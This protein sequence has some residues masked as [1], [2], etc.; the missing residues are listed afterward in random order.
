MQPGEIADWT[1]K[2]RAAGATSL[3][4]NTWTP[5]PAPERSA[6]IEGEMRNFLAQW[7]P[8]VAP[9]AGDQ[10]PPDFSAQCEAMLSARPTCVSSIMGL[11]PA[12]YVARLNEAGVKWFATATT[13]AEARAAA[14]AGADA[15]IAQGAEA[16]GH[17]GAFDAD[18]AERSMA[19]LF[20]LLPAIVDAVDVPVIAAGGIGDARGFAGALALGAH[21]VMIGTA[22][23]RCPE[24][25][26]PA[27]YS[28]ALARAQPE[29]TLV[30]RA[31]SGRPGRSLATGFALAAQS[32]GAPRA[33]PYP[34]QRGLTAQMRSKA[35]K[36]NDVER[37]Q[38]WAGQSAR[39]AQ[40]R[41]AG[42][43]VQSLW[44][45]ARRKFSP[46][47]GPE[48]QFPV[49]RRQSRWRMATDSAKPPGRWRKNDLPRNLCKIAER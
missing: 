41:P 17:R 30:T 38:A 31:F 26:S 32:A 43:I 37:M 15:I 7:G 24:A 6:R 4:L 33:A 21:A 40:A 2:F 5:Q 16:G 14:Q 49:C 18:V 13:V 11:F 44:R 23:L 25:Q 48:K 12:R 19:G 20:A 39:L 22:F 42:E 1:A 34:V 8:E 47:A 27:A 10:T 35:L 28:A 45:G 29:D 46:E 9:S 36:E 3:Q